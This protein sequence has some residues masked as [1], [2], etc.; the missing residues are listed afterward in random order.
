MHASLFFVLLVVFGA[1]FVINLTLAVISEQFTS[2]LARNMQ[3][4]T[5]LA[6]ERHPRDTR[7]AHP[8][9]S[10]RLHGVSVHA[11][12]SR[13]CV[14]TPASLL[15]HLAWPLRSGPRAPPPGAEGGARGGDRG[16]ARGGGRRTRQEHRHQAWRADGRG[17]AAGLHVAR[18]RA[19][20]REACADCNRSRGRASKELGA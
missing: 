2:R 12:L 16:G 19:C 10:W 15:L 11:R 14:F 5:V 3:V 4:R 9:P 6:R 18:C 8:A 13:G 17:G 7:V 1:F 20:S